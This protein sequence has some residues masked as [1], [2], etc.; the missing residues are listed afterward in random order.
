MLPSNT[1]QGMSVSTSSSI[2]S[3]GRR[4]L[5]AIIIALRLE[6]YTMP[7]IRTITIH[8][9]LTKRSRTHCM[10]NS[11]AAKLELI[12]RR[13]VSQY[14]SIPHTLTHLNLLV[15]PCP[16][17]VAKNHWKTSSHWSFFRFVVVPS[18]PS[19]LKQHIYTVNTSNYDT[20]RV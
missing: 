19:D 8:M 20:P 1:R 10:P 6:R 15:L 9:P 4:S 17:K 2:L 18:R 12:Q 11:K 5:G 16:T 13:G 14:V 7:T 3:K